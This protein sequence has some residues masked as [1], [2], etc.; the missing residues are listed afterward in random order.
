VRAGGWNTSTEN[1]GIGKTETEGGVD[2]GG[3]EGCHQD[4]CLLGCDTVHSGTPD[5]LLSPSSGQNSHSCHAEDSSKMAAV[6]NCSAPHHRIDRGRSTTSS[7]N[8]RAQR[9]KRRVRTGK[10]R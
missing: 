4:R 9:R 10:H 6:P 3:T 8:L 2:G 5:N 1:W 7:R